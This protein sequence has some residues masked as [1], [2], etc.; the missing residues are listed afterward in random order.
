MSTARQIPPLN[1][2]R[3]FEAAARH[4]S[5]TRAAE[6]LHVTPA[7]VSQQVKA[8]ERRLGLPLFRRVHN[9]LY[10]TPSG[11][12]WLPKITAG[13]D[14]IAS[15]V[16]PVPNE[17]AG[18]LIVRTPSSFSILWLAPRLYRFHARYPNVD[19]RISALGREAD[20]DGGPP[21]I[22]IRNGS[23]P[24]PGLER[25]LLMRE[26]VFPVCSPAVRRGPPGLRA[27][28]DLSRHT[29][30]HVSGYREDWQMWLAAAGAPDLEVQPGL[31][32]D[33]SVTAIQAAVNGVG[34]ALGRSA[35]V[36]GELAAGR[37]VAPFSIRL[38]AEEAYWIA[39]RSQ[40]ERHPAVRAFRDWLLQEASLD[41]GPDAQQRH[42][43]AP[44]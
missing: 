26:E 24:W 10:L 32:F 37:L 27:I 29:L 38:Q 40:V 7:A 30:L 25:V 23:S 18:T 34:V 19:V 5:F 4:L 15:G 39:W 43:G 16:H 17:R 12:S 41:P 42:G 28:K 31:H 11:Q 36:A 14:L 6:E 44:A 1:W 33:Q 3:A 35:L 13:L 8:L 2:I 9:R 22:E 20:T 21:D